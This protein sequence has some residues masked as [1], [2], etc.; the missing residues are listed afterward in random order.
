VH[1]RGAAWPA[2]RPSWPARPW[3]RPR[4]RSGATTGCARASWT[5]DVPP[6]PPPR[7]RRR[8]GAACGPTTGR[9][10]SASARRRRALQSAARTWAKTRSMLR[11]SS[12][13]QPAADHR[14]RDQGEDRH[15]GDD[16]RPRAAPRWLACVTSVHRVPPRRLPARNPVRWSSWQAQCAPMRRTARTTP[17]GSAGTPSGR[18]RRLGARAVGTRPA[19]EGLVRSRAS[20]LPTP[21]DVE[22][23]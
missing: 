10:S 19:G 21:A 11:A 4:P 18:P 3:Q 15:G 1:R 23:A 20:L 14:G 17:S 8:L 7:K 16:V 2:K 9:D 12:A 5:G 6:S 22:T 13:E